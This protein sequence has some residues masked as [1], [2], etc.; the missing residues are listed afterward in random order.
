MATLALRPLMPSAHR[1]LVSL[2]TSPFPSG[3]RPSRPRRHHRQPGLACLPPALPGPPLPRPAAHSSTQRRRSL[4]DYRPS[5]PRVCPTPDD[6]IPLRASR[7]LGSRPRCTAAPLHTGENLKSFRGDTNQPPR[8]WAPAQLYS[9]DPTFFLLGAQRSAACPQSASPTDLRGI[10]GPKDSG[11]KNTQGPFDAPMTRSFAQLPTFP[12]HLLHG[13]N[14]Y[15]TSQTLLIR[16]LR[17]PT[18]VGRRVVDG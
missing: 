2:R 17:P 8:F 18:I 11:A 9:A 3:R 7:F 4:L 5:A 1:P 15:I 13:G 6:L 16:V 10:M 14:F 12:T